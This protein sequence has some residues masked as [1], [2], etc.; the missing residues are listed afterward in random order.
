MTK[1]RVVAVARRVVAAARRVIVVARRVVV[2]AR[3]MTNCCRRLP[4]HP[5]LTPPSHIKN[6]ILGTRIL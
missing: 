6:L 1:G 3:P 4:T 5:R 2:V